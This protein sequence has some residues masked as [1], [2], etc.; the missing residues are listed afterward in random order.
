M[1][2]SWIGPAFMCGNGAYLGVAAMSIALT[3]MAGAT[4][5]QRFEQVLN[6]PSGGAGRGDLAL[7]ALHGF[8]DH[9]LLG[10]GFGAFPPNSF[11]LLR[12]TPGVY[13]D[14]HLRCLAGGSTVRAA[15]S[16][17]TGQPVH[18]TYVESLVE[19]GIPGVLLFCGVL[20]A[21]GW[22]LVRTSRLAR[23]ANDS[24]S[25]S[26]A[27]ALAIGLLGF[28]L[29]STTLST[30]TNRTPWMIVALSLALPSMVG[31]A[32]LWGEREAQP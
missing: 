28:A 24:F 27:A 20:V 25:A 11:Q 21:A 15:G 4:L 14:L 10:M 8:H 9:P 3:V 18:N 23:V 19:L 7:A 22:S 5:S 17:C 13:L 31:P 6:D 32:R 16:F 1:N 29:V 26:I 2:V 30:E 12:S